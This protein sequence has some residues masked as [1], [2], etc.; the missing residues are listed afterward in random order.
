M[1]KAEVQLGRVYAAKVSDRIAPVRLDRVNPYG[2]WDATNLRTDRLVR[3]KSAAKLR[4]EVVPNPAHAGRWI[5]K[6]AESI[7]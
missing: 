3:I 1:H 4:F 5:R 7:E 6:V 2:G